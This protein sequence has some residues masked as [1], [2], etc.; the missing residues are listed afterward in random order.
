MIDLSELLQREFLVVI[1]TT[2]RSSIHDAFFSAANKVCEDMGRS[3]ESFRNIYQSQKA[4]RSDGYLWFQVAESSFDTY[5]M[6]QSRKR[7]L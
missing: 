1:R 3:S 4:F 6:I 7:A 5:M 2:P